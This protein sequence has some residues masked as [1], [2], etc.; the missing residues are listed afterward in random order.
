MGKKR[1]RLRKRSQN[2][3]QIPILKIQI[4]N[5]IRRLSFWN[6]FFGI[7]ILFRFTAF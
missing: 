3:G 7:W 6:L 1:A 4:P 5:K 2:T